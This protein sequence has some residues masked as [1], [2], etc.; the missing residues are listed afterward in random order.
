MI[1][2][3]YNPDTASWIY[4]GADK[5][6]VCKRWLGDKGFQ[7]F[8]EDMGKRPTP[9]HRLSRLDKK[10]DYTPQN[11]YWATPYQCNRNKSTNTFYEVDGKKK[12]LVDWARLYSIPKS[13]LHYRVVTVGMKMKDAL[14]L[15]R[16]T[17]GKL[18]NV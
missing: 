1:G 7:N 8:L 12:C 16:G 11:T 4:I 14:K 18:L 3:C 6:K 15:G 2:N 13:T 10:R 5:I 9:K 17:C